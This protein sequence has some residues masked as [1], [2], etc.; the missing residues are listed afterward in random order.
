MS[1]TLEKAPTKPSL[2]PITLLFAAGFAVA[3]C[4]LYVFMGYLPWHIDNNDTTAV[5]KSLLSGGLML[6]GV[7]LCLGVVVAVIMVKPQ[8]STTTP[9]H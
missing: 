3:L 2:P 6:L 7:S 8:S 9:T 5:V 4:G 1:S